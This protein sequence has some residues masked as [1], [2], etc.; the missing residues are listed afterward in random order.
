MRKRDYRD[1]LQDIIDSINDIEDFTKNM[2]FEDFAR[3]KKTI[4]AVIRV[5]K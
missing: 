4:N 3:D 5:T 1:Y 2:S